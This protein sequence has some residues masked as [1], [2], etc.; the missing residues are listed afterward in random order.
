MLKA[1][2]KHYPEHLGFLFWKNSDGVTVCEAAWQHMKRM[3]PSKSFKSVSQLMPIILSSIMSSN[4]IL[5]TWMILPCAILLQYYIYEMINKGHSNTRYWVVG[6][7]SKPML[8]LYYAWEMMRLK[9]ETLWLICTHS[10]LQPRQ[11]HQICQQFIV[12]W[13]AIHHCWKGWGDL[14]QSSQG[15]LKQKR[16]WLLFA[17]GNKMQDYNYVHVN[18]VEAGR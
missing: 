1:G 6:W 7:V 9:R 14:N 15:R 12:C 11:R 3:R 18:R 13:D 4:T 2:M 8:C 10:R 16:K 5:S 17:S